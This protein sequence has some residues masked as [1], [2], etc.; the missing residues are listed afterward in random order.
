MTNGGV[1]SAISLRL[2]LEESQK[3]LDD[4]LRNI[5]IM[6]AC[7]LVHGDLSAFNVLWWRGQVKIIDLPQ[8]VE[9][10]AP[11]AYALLD[12]DVRN[13]CRYFARAGTPV[14]PGAIAESLWRRRMQ[15]AL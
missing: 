15:G 14:D 9:A 3:A 5:E 4:L 2:S 1:R 6:L 13:V 10:S 11:D 12:R 8:A 7:E